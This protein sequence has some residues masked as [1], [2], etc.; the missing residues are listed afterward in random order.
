[1]MGNMVIPH[2]DKCQPFGL[3]SKE[4]RNHKVTVCVLF[5]NLAGLS[6]PAINHHGYRGD[7]LISGSMFRKRESDVC[8][9][10][11]FL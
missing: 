5:G 11:V 7:W 3:H 9:T 1:M 6:H 2:S 10:Y 8:H 4:A